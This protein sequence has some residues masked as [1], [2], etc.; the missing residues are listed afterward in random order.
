MHGSKRQRTLR[1]GQPDLVWGKEE[2]TEKYP[3]LISEG[4]ELLGKTDY[5]YK[6]P[7]VTGNI[8][9]MVRVQK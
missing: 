8:A 2:F 6:S 3:G 4:W 5:K 1:R 9:G 7:V